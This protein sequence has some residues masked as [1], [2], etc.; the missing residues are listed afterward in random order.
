MPNP[1]KLAISIAI[2]SENNR[3]Q[4]IANCAKLGYQVCTGKVGT[5]NP[6]K[7]ISAVITACKR[8]NIW[9]GS[10]FR[11]EHALY[12]C[13]IE[14]LNGVC[15]GQIA[16]SE[17]LRTVGLNFAVLK[18]L[19]PLHESDGDWVIVCFYGTIGAPIRGFEHETIGLGINHF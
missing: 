14:A 16:L 18:G 15:R 9:D 17:S 12:D 2:A 1:G 6:E 10:S 4:L 11:Q 19:L 7:I 5:M 13:I 8:E 3:P